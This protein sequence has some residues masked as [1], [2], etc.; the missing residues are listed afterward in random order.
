MIARVAL[1]ASLA[2]LPWQPLDDAARAAVQA[3]RAPWLE[4]PMRIA[5]EGARPALFASVAIAAVA[6]PA[7]RA[8]ALEAGVALAPVNLV[9]EGLK[10]AVDRHRPSGR[11]A[12]S[13]AAFPSSHAAN[14][15]AFAVVIARR[16]RRWGVALPAF[17]LAAVVGYSRLYLDRH[18][19]SDVVAGAVLGAAIA[20]WTV[21]AWRRW[22][23]RRRGA[24]SA[25]GTSDA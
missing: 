16:W 10:Y 13:N 8:F 25:L 11:H 9:V 20:W 4:R 17:A 23:A 6:G 1:V 18:W 24:R 15:F 21:G 22:L 14:A 12:R 19:L 7:G 5:S 3:G 2:S